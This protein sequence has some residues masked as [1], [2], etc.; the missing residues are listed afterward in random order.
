[1]IEALSDTKALVGRHFRHI[2]R[3]PEQLLSVTLMPIAFVVIFGMLFGS[4]ME[5][6]GSSYEEYIMAGIFIQ[7]MMSNVSTTALGVV[8]DL[9][10]GLVDRFRS[11]PISRSAVLIGRTTADMA[12]AAWSCALMAGVGY[13]IGW[14]IHNGI[15]SALGGFALLLLLG[16]TMSWLG[17]LLGLALRSPE[18]VNAL[19]FM[20]MMPMMFLSNAFVPLDGLP[21]WL[22]TI[23]EWNPISSVVTAC[24]ELFGNPTVGTGT[25]ITSEHPVVMSLVLIGAVLAIVVPMSGRV[26]RTAVAR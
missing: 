21:A 8:G 24:R 18:A 25:G 2:V 13:L 10:N 19:A 12:L 9:S 1:M 15:L 3:I 6:K 22:R 20:A 11:L 17:A 14:R 26:Y 4:A 16:F 23:A 5:V 7:V